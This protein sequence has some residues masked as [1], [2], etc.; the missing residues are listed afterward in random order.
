MRILRKAATVF[1]LFSLVVS[2]AFAGGTQEDSGR[3]TTGAAADDGSKTLYVAYDREI[4]VLNPFTSQML[5][6]IQHNISEG[7]IITNDHNE[8][9]PVL[10]REIPTFDNGGIVQNADGTYDM[11]WHLREGVTWSDGEPFTAED[12]AF[13]LEYVQHTPEVYNQSEYNKIISYEIVDDHT[14]VMTWDDF[15]TF[16]AGLFEAMLPK[17]VLEDLSWEEITQYE[18]YNRGPEFIGTGPFVFAEWKSGEYIRIERNPDYWRGP[19]YPLLDEM[20]FQFIPDQTA[21]FNAM[22]SGDYH[23]GQIEAT[24]VDDFS[25]DGLHVEMIPSNVFYYVGFNIAPPGGRPDLFGD[26]LVRQAFY[27]AIDRQAI[28]DQ[29]LEGTVQIANSPIPPS[30]A[31]HN[32]DV[33]V[34]EYNPE[35]AREMLAEAG[36]EDTNGNGIIDKDG[37]EFSFEWLNRSGRADR[38]AIAQVIQ[39]QLKQVGIDSTMDELEAAAWS[40]RWRNFD[41]EAQIGGWFMGSDVSLTN[42]YHTRDGESGSNNFSGFGDPE[43]DQLMTES[44]TMV[45]FDSRKPLLD[46]A[47]ERLADDAFV[48]FLYYRDSPWVVAD[49]LTNFRGSGTNL[50]NWWNAWEWDLE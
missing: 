12:V 22:Q 25:T 6:D 35:H 46:A 40:Q 2:G 10:A 1:A 21:R 45:D 11:T 18:P 5:C 32:P 26:K 16:Y 42:F 29:L 15:Y 27:A 8:F 3:A 17:H 24:Q 41:Y 48:I 44:D 23:I 34:P 19:E 49:N 37:V 28:V 9:I 47:Q 4:D 30:S 7:L 20:V 38:I 39:A 36:W 13:T 50:G 14:I 31:Y 43:L 33:E